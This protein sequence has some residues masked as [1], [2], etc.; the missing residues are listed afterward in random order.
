MREQNPVVSS[1][2]EGSDA[3]TLYNMHEVPLRDCDDNQEN[4]YN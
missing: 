4:M 1:R 3:K 2:Q